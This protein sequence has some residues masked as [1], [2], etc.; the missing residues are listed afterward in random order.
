MARV[1]SPNVRLWAVAN[2]IIVVAS[3]SVSAR[4]IGATL[5]DVSKI[6]RKAVS[7]EEEH[8]IFIISISQTDEILKTKDQK[9]SESIKVRSN[10]SKSVRVGR[11]E[12]FDGIKDRW[13]RQAVTI[14]TKEESKLFSS[15]HGSI[16]F[17]CKSSPQAIVVVGCVWNQKFLIIDDGLVLL[18][19]GIISI[20][21]QEESQLISV[22][23]SLVDKGNFQFCSFGESDSWDGSLV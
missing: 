22:S 19:R 15:N 9:L 10:V 14:S 4:R 7:I 3:S 8:A 16:G 21:E 12:F 13:V 18:G 23:C 6:D 2:S 17:N 11:V 5:S 1:G 20:M